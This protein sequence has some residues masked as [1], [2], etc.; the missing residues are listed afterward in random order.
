MTAP[1]CPTNLPSAA[2]RIT[3]RG[4]KHLI[5]AILNFTPMNTYITLLRGINVAGQKIIHMGDLRSWLNH[6]ELLNVKT[7]I[8]SGNLIL[9]SH[10]NPH[11]VSNT[12]SSIILQ[13]TNF[14]IDTF[15]LTPDFLLQIVSQN[16]FQLLASRNQHVYVS[17]FLSTIPANAFNKIEPLSPHEHV[18]LHENH[19]YFFPENGYSSSK[20][21]NNFFE[22]KLKTTCTTRNMKTLETLLE[23]SSNSFSI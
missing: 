7:Y 12:I 4:S 6:P 9:H 23:M 18:S 17:F 16:P 11:D 10:L 8:Q 1:K 19:L 20:L 2:L 15:T 5:S 13:K 22:K 21:N 14:E 3:E